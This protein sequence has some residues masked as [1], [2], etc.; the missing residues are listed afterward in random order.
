MSPTRRDILKAS[1][2]AVTAALVATNASDATVA[3][4]VATEPLRIESMHYGMML[5][6]LSDGQMV[7]LSWDRDG[8]QLLIGEHWDALREIDD[9]KAI[10]LFKKHN[11]MM[12]WVILTCAGINVASDVLPAHVRYDEI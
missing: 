1:A 3:S 6:K 12:M 9:P 11:E 7:N 4:S 8:G 10:A 5:V 2:G